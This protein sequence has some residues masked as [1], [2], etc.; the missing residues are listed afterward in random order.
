VIVLGTKVS[1]LIWFC[2]V[3]KYGDVAEY[4]AIR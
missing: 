2:G 3:E 1:R 4:L